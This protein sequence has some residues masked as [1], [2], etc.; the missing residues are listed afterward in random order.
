MRAS[1]E[2]P[3]GSLMS[4]P[5]PGI[6]VELSDGSSVGPES[7]GLPGELS[8]S[9]GLVSGGKA[10]GAV[11]FLIPGGAAPASVSYS[12]DFD[13]SSS[14]AVSAALGKIP[15]EPALSVSFP[16]P[17]AK[18]APDAKDGYAVEFYSQT[19]VAP[20]MRVMGSWVKSLAVVDSSGKTVSENS[21]EMTF[22]ESLGTVS[23][24]SGPQFA[25]PG[26]D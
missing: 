24:S 26:G 2:N 25:G 23:F 15:Q 5:S 8:V 18:L 17:S 16:E 7:T 1:L 20:E 11:I 21:V 12:T 13:P 14:A 3:T 9:S 10:E 22:V 19:Q 4:F 6:Y